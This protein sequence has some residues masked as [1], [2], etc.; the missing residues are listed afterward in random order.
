MKCAALLLSV[1]VLTVPIVGQA[2]AAAPPMLEPVSSWTLD[3]A[4][5]RCSLTRDFARGSDSIRLRIDSYGPAPGYRVT[6]S[7]DLVPGSPS[8]PI[9]EFRVAYS[10]DT[11]ERERMSMPAGKVGDEN[12]VSFGPAFLPDAPW[13]AA[14]PREFER[15]VTQMTVEF[16]LHP[17][18]RLDTGNMAEPFAAMHKCIDDLV[19]SWGIDPVQYSTQARPPVLLK[20]PDGYR[21]AKVDLRERHPGP[22]ARRFRAIAEADAKERM[23]PVPQA[24]Y[25]APVRI[26]VDASGKPGA[27]VAQVASLDE[28]QRQAICAQYAGPYQP[29]LD[30]AGRP[31]ASF[32]Q[33][34]LNPVQYAAN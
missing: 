24:G 15:G 19:A 34:G 7:G 5:E 16:R 20:L 32:V 28:A 33:P 6:I 31:M 26:M 18:F 10:P 25:V 27:C 22:T 9:D 17:P 12:A 21:E 30:A 3:F 11:R 2:A 29:A 13:A 8:A 1:T 4:Q 14:K 23:E